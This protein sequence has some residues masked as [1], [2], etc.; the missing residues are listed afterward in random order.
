MAYLTRQ[1]YL[2]FGL[3]A[4]TEEAFPALASQVSGEAD[5]L[6]FGW[7]AEHFDELPS[8]GSDAQ[9]LKAA[10]AY[11]IDFIAAAAGSRE[12]SLKPSPA[13]VS[14]TMGN[15]SYSESYGA[16]GKGAASGIASRWSK[17]ALSCLAPFISIGR[18]GGK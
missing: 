3:S 9:R 11:Q 7:L 15:Y 16:S 13:S 2:S 6:T 14:E 4:V 8:D 5:A 10:V 12:E 1:E 18:G 17:L